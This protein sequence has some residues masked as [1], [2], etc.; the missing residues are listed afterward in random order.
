MSCFSNLHDFFVNYIKNPLKLLCFR[1]TLSTDSNIEN[2]TNVQKSSY[3]T[4]SWED[5]F[6]AFSFLTR[7]CPIVQDVV[8]LGSFSRD[9]K[10]SS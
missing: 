5:L 2:I 6:W 1:K 7:S 3:T 8:S 4:V 10:S 9:S